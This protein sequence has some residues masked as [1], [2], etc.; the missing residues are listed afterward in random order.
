MDDEVVQRA[1]HPGS[2]RFKR[3][4]DG[5]CAARR[6]QLC[7]VSVDS[8]TDPP[9][10]VAV[11]SGSH[12]RT[13]V[14]SGVPVG[15]TLVF[16]YMLSGLSAALASVIYTARL[17]TG[18]PVLGQRL[19]LHDVVAAVVIGG[20]SLFG[21]RGRVLWTVWG[22]LFITLVDNTLNLVGVSNFAVLMVKGVVILGAALLD[23][24]R[25]LRAAA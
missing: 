6:S 9:G 16:A 15:R 5:S 2:F 3:E 18:S 17:E 22:V 8:D 10:T 19:L 24:A 25:S 20:T 1:G 13:A 7:G 14:A 11:R 12:V 4:S 21:G 23:R